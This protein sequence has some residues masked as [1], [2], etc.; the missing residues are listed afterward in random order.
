VISTRP[1]VLPDHIASRIRG[2]H[3]ELKRKLRA[4]LGE[5]LKDPSSG[6]PLRDELEGLRSFRVGRIRIIYR[7][8]PACIHIITIG[9]RTTVYQETLRLVRRDRRRSHR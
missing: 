5:T 1:F 2:A 9:S 8:A 7:E 4:A 3:P 6:K